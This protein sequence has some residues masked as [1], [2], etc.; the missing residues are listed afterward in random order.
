MIVVPVQLADR[1]YE[2]LVGDGVRSELSRVIPDQAKRVAIVTQEGLG[3]EVDPGREHKV[4]TMGDGEQSKS[5][6]TVESLCRQFAQWGLTRADCVVAVGGGIVTDTSGYAAASYHRGVPVVHVSTTLVGQVDAAIGGKTGV[7]IPEGK[8]LIGAYWQPS[9]VVCDTGLLSTLPPREYRCGLGEIAK[10]HFLG[11]EGLDALP[12]D[13][14]VAACVAI[15][16]AVVASDEREGGARATLN[17]GHTLAHAIEIAGDHDLRHGEAVA[18]GLIFAAELALRLGRIDEDRVA[19][20]R[21][22][23]G[24]YDLP[25]TL[26]TGLENS[27]LIALMGRDKKALDGITFVLDGPNGVESVTGVDVSLIEDSINAIRIEGDR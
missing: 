6:A 23:V 5:M 18:I 8:N 21:R 25:L 15:K 19:E 20:H 4:F 11:G 2:V 27:E 9:G 7:N 13:E 1:S 26:P 14:Q 16:A 24:A 3:I 17:Y 22:V 10:Y 12:I